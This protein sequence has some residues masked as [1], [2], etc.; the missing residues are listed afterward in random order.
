M[1]WGDTLTSPACGDCW[2]SLLSPDR[3]KA[4]ALPAQAVPV[5]LVSA[6]TGTSPHPHAAASIRC[7]WRV[8]KSRA[9]CAVAPLYLRGVSWQEPHGDA[10]SSW[11]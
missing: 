6:R 2:Q 4:P 8:G 9:W 10:A 5:K 11:S 1:W 3:E 7:M